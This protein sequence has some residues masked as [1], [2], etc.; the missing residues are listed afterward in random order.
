V[1]R[2]QNEKHQVHVMLSKPGQMPI[3]DSRG[4]RCYH[5]I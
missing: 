2:G 3:I 1:E 5:A 4:L